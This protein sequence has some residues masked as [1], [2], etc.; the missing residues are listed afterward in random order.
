MKDE[1]GAIAIALGSDR[2]IACVN[3]DSVAIAIFQLGK[4]D[5]MESCA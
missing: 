3:F 2:I 4:H 1:Y 5:T